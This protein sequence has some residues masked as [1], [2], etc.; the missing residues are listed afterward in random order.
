[1]AIDLITR[2]EW[3]ARAPKGDYDTLART[4]GVKVHS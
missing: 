4:R 1:M 2:A 3:R